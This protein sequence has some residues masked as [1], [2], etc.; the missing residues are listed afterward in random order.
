MQNMQEAAEDDE[1][2]QH[3]GQKDA[4]RILQTAAAALNALGVSEGVLDEL[5]LVFLHS[6]SRSTYAHAIMGESVVTF[7]NQKDNCVSSSHPLLLDISNASMLLLSALTSTSQ[8]QLSD[9]ELALRIG[10]QAHVT[11]YIV[12]T[13]RDVSL[14]D[15]MRGRAQRM[16]DY[17]PGG[18][19]KDHLTEIWRWCRVNSEESPQQKDVLVLCKKGLQW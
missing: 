1:K 13:A 15:Y 7:Y 5:S 2:K 14:Q 19:S 18:V 6:I 12:K 11:P 10:T 17:R 4:R 3:S 8:S 9:R 16:V